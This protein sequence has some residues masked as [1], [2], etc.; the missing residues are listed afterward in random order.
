MAR[1][2]FSNPPPAEPNWLDRKRRELARAMKFS[3]TASTPWPEGL[4]VTADNMFEFERRPS[5]VAPDPAG[6]R[7]VA[8]TV[9]GHVPSDYEQGG[10]KEVVRGGLTRTRD[11]LSRAD[12]GISQA[13]NKAAYGQARAAEIAARRSQEIYDRSY[14]TPRQ[15]DVVNEIPGMTVYGSDR[16]PQTPAAR[17][18]LLR[19][20]GLTRIVK[21]GDGSYSNDPNAQGEVRLYDEMGARADRMPIAGGPRA[22][23]VSA[24]QDWSPYLGDAVNGGDPAI[25]AYNQRVNAAPR[26]SGADRIAQG[27]RSLERASE[28]QQR[29]AAQAEADFMASLSPKDRAQMQ[30]EIMKDQSANTRAQEQNETTLLAARAQRRAILEAAGLARADKVTERSDTLW[31]DN[32]KQAAT[33]LMAKYAKASN[34]EQ[35]AILNSPEG[36]QLFTYMEQNLARDTSLPQEVNKRLSALFGVAPASIGPKLDNLERGKI[37]GYRWKDAPYTSPGYTGEEDLGLSPELFDLATKA[38]LRKKANERP[39]K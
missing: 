23:P 12:N 28:N 9:L 32:Q 36:S 21:T 35:D 20:N 30:T 14:D 13:I 16:A 17:D 7:R 34:D 1:I 10:V 24:S 19:E 33:Q 27:R 8:A 38:Y 25:A 18:G 2:D 29:M 3:R 11:M 5:P 37:S 26:T 6:E 31:Q 4:P 15:E 22:A 39:K